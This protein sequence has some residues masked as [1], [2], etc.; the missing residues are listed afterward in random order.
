MPSARQDHWE[1]G[2]IQGPRGLGGDLRLRLHQPDPMVLDVEQ[3]TLDARD[4]QRSTLAI[5]AVQPIGANS[6]IIRL[7]GV[8]SR[9]SA[10]RLTGATVIVERRWFAP[11]ALPMVALIGAEAVNAETKAPVGVV[12]DVLHNGA[13][14]VLVIGEEPD[15]RM[16]PLVDALATVD[17]DGVVQ[18][19]PLPGLID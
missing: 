7:Q 4:G 8:R 10:E 18:I 12:S 13:Q 14:Y 1:I 9:E 11:D 2:Y 15:E 6:A 19:Q 3:L 17:A 16:I 5:E